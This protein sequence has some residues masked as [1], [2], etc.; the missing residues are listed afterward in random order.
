MK[1]KPPGDCNI[2]NRRSL[3]CVIVRLIN[4]H[5]C[6]NIYKTQLNKTSIHL[7]ANIDNYNCKDRNKKKREIDRETK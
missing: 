6:L 7:I 3:R 5:T 2:K 1:K 4:M